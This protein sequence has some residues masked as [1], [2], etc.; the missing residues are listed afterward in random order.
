MWAENTYSA[1][2]NNF[3]GDDEAVEKAND[4]I[5]FYQKALLLVTCV[6]CLIFLIQNRKNISLDIIFLITIFIGG[7][8]FH[9][10][11]EAKSR[12][13]IPYIVV[14]IPVAS[15]TI[16][17]IKIKSLKKIKIGKKRGKVDF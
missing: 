8:S 5:E 3:S 14:L 4:I 16:K 6:C 2:R 10:L 11:W 9:I 13:I 1:V 15:M 7:F 17:N 12:Y